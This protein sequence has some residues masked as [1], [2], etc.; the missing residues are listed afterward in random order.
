MHYTI[1][2]DFHIP[3]H[4]RDLSKQIS[5]KPIF[6]WYTAREKNR[7]RADCAGHTVSRLL[8]RMAH[9]YAPRR[10]LLILLLQLL[11]LP[12]CYR[13][14]T[15][16]GTQAQA[17]H[18]HRRSSFRKIAAERCRLYY[19]LNAA[20][21]LANSKP[22]ASLLLLP[23][24][25]RDFLPCSTATWSTPRCTCTCGYM[26]WPHANERTKNEKQQKPRDQATTS[27]GAQRDGWEWE[28]DGDVW[29][30]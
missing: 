1:K 10:L 25:L 13:A 5:W 3:S 16:F 19:S 24:L 8:P 14:H 22:I 20:F 26:R 6:R 11:L 4:Y 28:R 2:R 12:H 21:S 7:W 27:T 9:T 15:R 30:V 29:I 17:A 18:A 23:I